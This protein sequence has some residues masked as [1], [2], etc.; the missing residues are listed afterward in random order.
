MA[1]RGEP[2]NN[3]GVST[4]GIA[5]WQFGLLGVLL[6]ALLGAVVFRVLSALFMRGGA[7]GLFFFLSFCMMTHFRIPV[8]MD[9]TLFAAG[10]VVVPLLI[11]FGGFRF[12]TG[13]AHRDAVRTVSF[14]RVP[15]FGHVEP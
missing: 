9:E 8:G 14:Q 1:Y 12:A 5:Y 10:Q 15:R 2:Q 6:T 3:G 11:T 13:I 7:V 4:S